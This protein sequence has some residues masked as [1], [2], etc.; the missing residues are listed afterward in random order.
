MTYCVLLLFSM[1]S[2]LKT[3]IP[4]MLGTFPQMGPQESLLTGFYGA[5]RVKSLI[6]F[7]PAENPKLD[8]PIC[9]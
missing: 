8:K 1:I 7:D 4:A 9:G 5:S 2:R 6:L 3:L